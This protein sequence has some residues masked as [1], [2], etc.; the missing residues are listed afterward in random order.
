VVRLSI[1]SILIVVVISRIGS[2]GRLI[3]AELDVVIVDRFG[4]IRDIALDAVFEIVNCVNPAAGLLFNRAAWFVLLLRFLRTAQTLGWSG[5]AEVGGAIAS[6]GSGR[7]AVAA[8]AGPRATETAWSSTEAAA[9]GTRTTEPA[10]GTRPRTAEAAGTWSA[11]RT[12]LTRARFA[13]RQAAS[14][15]RLRVEALDDL[16][17]F[18]AFDELDKRE[19]AGAAGLTIDRHDDMGGLCD[20]RKVSTEVSLRG[21][22]GQI[23]DEQ[24]DCQVLLV[25]D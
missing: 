8:T 18:L 21:A 6:T 22:V 5:R 17:S 25:K 7:A 11:W 24:T 20:W 14:L 23:P 19:A 15:E 9:T 16:F 13:D 12:I 2:G 1:P 10:R 4:K 3:V